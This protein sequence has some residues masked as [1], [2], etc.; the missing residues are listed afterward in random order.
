M[1]WS[2][3]VE[4]LFKTSFERSNYFQE[5]AQKINTSLNQAGLKSSTIEVDYGYISS[6]YREVIIS[7]LKSDLKDKENE[8]LRGILNLDSEKYLKLGMYNI[9][10]I[11]E[12][13]SPTFSIEQ[14]N[15]TEFPDAEYSFYI[16]DNQ[17][18]KTIRYF[19][20]IVKNGKM[21]K[22]QKHQKD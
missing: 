14:L 19:S 4:P 18:D 11:L 16:K 2:S 21:I 12:E 1:Y 10:V 7:E 3:M 17:S 15:V 13:K 22:I 20:L 6:P 5:V 8:P 9:E